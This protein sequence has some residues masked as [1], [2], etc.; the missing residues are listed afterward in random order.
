MEKK[1]TY[2]RVVDKSKSV[3]AIIDSVE[4]DMDVLLLNTEDH[5][6]HREMIRAEAAFSE[7]EK[8]LQELRTGVKDVIR[9]TES[10]PRLEAFFAMKHVEE[11][12]E[13]GK[14]QSHI[15]QVVPQGIQARRPYDERNISRL[16]R[17][18]PSILGLSVK[19]GKGKKQHLY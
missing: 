7:M 3:K 13:N 12:A 17:M 9:T 6:S 14:I 19:K 5:A 11:L 18:T 1:E 15:P 2:F 8:H 16:G 4:E 10:S